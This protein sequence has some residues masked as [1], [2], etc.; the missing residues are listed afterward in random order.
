MAEALPLSLLYGWGST[1]ISAVWLRLYLHLCCMAETLLFIHLCCIAEILL[2]EVEERRI[3]G[4]WLG[5]YLHLCCM[6]EALFFSPGTKLNTTFTRC[7]PN[8]FISAFTRSCRSSLVHL[9]YVIIYLSIAFSFLS[10]LCSSSTHT[11]HISLAYVTMPCTHLCLLVVVVFSIH[12][13]NIFHV[14]FLF[15]H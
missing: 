2:S 7:N 6:A 9:Y 10:S 14:W 3:F 4:V 5:R 1:F 11:A 8:T 15:W 12:L 13:L